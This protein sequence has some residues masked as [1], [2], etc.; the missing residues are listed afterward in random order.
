VFEV[1]AQGV[2]PAFA[3]LRWPRRLP[4]IRALLR[5]PQSSP[6]RAALPTPKLF[7]SVARLSTNPAD[8]L[9]AIR[10]HVRYRQHR[11]RAAWRSPRP[12]R[13]RRRSR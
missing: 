12:P 5:A 6:L 9:A 3:A 8:W 4:C 10:W 13:R 2:R 1:V 11:G 7:A